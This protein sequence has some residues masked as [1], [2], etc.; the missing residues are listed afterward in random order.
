M[1]D[2]F[3]SMSLS[4]ERGKS[5]GKGERGREEGDSGKGEMGEGGRGKGGRGRRTKNRGGVENKSATT[6]KETKI[7]NLNLTRPCSLQA[8]WA[9]IVKLAIHRLGGRYVILRGV[10]AAVRLVMP[11]P[12]LL[13]LTKDPAQ[14]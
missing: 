4:G 5:R 8:G 1:S 10:V 14:G 3:G 11:A 9:D 7:K 2:Y 12:L 6:G 13:Q